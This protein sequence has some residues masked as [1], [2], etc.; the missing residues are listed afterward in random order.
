MLAERMRKEDDM[1]AEIER[2]KRMLKSKESLEGESGQLAARNAEL[3]HNLAALRE[4]LG[5]ERERDAYLTESKWKD[6]VETLTLQLKKASLKWKQ[7][8]TAQGGQ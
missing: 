3:E 1:Q 8:E 6:Q 2:L 4:S 5:Q 7:L